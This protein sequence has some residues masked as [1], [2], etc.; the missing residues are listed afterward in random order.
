MSLKGLW[1]EILIPH[2]TYF[3]KRW[4]KWN[5]KLDGKRPV[6]QFGY[7]SGDRDGVVY[8]V[9]IGDG[10]SHGCTAMVRHKADDLRVATQQEAAKLNAAY[11]GG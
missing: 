6:S 7:V 1:V 10:K 5:E 8:V 11:F 3:G 2:A 9:L 4:G